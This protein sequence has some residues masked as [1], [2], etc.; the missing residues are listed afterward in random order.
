MTKTEKLTNLFDSWKSKFYANDDFYK[1]GIIN[2]TLYESAN[3]KLLY[4]TKEPNAVNHEKNED[5]SFVTEWNTTVPTYPFSHRIA[6][7]TYGI[8]NKFPVYSEAAKNAMKNEMLKKIAFMNL[9]KSGGTGNSEK[10]TFAALMKDKKHLEFIHEQISIINPE[11]IIFGLASWHGLVEKS[12][13]DIVWNDDYSYHVKTGMLGT[14][15]VINFYHPSARNVPA[16]SYS[17][18]ENVM[19]TQGF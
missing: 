9:K 14:K 7:W 12:F 10:E 1:D 19:K 2:E 16:A 18:L 5:R 15:K 3:R 4:I 8:L 6:E 13:A 11:L 17:L